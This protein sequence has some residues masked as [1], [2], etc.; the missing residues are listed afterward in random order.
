MIS[1][2]HVAANR[3]VIQPESDPGHGFK[4]KPGEMLEAKVLKQMP[5][6]SIQLLIQGRILTVKTALLLDTG[7]RVSLV[8]SQEGDATVFKLVSPHPGTGGG[9]ISTGAGGLPKGIDFKALSRLDSPKIKTLLSQWALHSAEPDH[10]ILSKFLDAGGLLWEKKI[11]HLASLPVGD[12]I[13]AAPS[14]LF[15]QDI[16]GLMLQLL[17]QYDTLDASARKMLTEFVQT[18]EKFQVLNQQ[19]LD[20]GKSLIPFP[21]F[22]PD[23]FSFG[24]IFIDAGKQNKQSEKDSERV[25]NVSLLL[26]MSN[27]GPVR[28]DFSMF[29][30]ALSG[31][32]KLANQETCDFIKHLLPRLKVRLIDNGY[33]VHELFCEVARTEEIESSSLVESLLKQEDARVLNV[34]V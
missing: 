27:L 1:G 15:S 14:T 23:V 4:F 30:K 7:T 2:I 22:G 29:K 13:K 10:Q 16:K 24:Q 25:I 34:V 18:I 32:F 8:P 3:M 9:T 19:V 21:I 31:G 33:L 5:R 26:N 20:T 12:L 6:G 17:K 11:G 28:A